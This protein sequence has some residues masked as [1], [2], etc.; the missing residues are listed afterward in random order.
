MFCVRFFLEPT[1]KRPNCVRKLILNHVKYLSDVSPAVELEQQTEWDVEKLPHA[2]HTDWLTK[3]HNQQRH[4]WKLTYK[5]NVQ[6]PRKEHRKWE[7]R[8]LEETLDDDEDL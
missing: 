4:Y 1:I 7:N 5:Q 8:F 6:H 3:D 2:S